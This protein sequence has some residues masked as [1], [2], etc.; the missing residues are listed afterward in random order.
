MM[1]PIPQ[2]WQLVDENGHI[3]DSNI[4][5]QLRSFGQEVVRP[6]RQFADEGISDHADSGELLR[7]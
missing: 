2:V 4:G 6:A 1:I 7:Q 3:V 5:K